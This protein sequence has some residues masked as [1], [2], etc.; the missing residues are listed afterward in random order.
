M[1]TQKIQGQGIV[2]IWVNSGQIW[3]NLPQKLDGKGWV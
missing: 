3:V 2:G 1:M